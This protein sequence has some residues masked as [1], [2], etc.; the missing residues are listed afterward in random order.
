MRVYI[1]VC[2][3]IFA[4]VAIAHAM[5]LRGGGMWHL[6]EADFVISSLAVLAMLGWSIALLI[7]R[8]K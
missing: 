2:G 6:R 3:I 8:S 4:F 5:E 7:R 1:V